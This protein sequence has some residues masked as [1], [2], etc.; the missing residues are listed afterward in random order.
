VVAGN[1]EE[2]LADQG[3]DVEQLELDDDT[4]LRVYEISKDNKRYY[5]HFLSTAQGTVYL[6]KPEQLS[7]EEVEK[8]VG[9]TSLNPVRRFGI[10]IGKYLQG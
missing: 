10:A 8:V 7:R 4:G 2:K 1:L 5:L 3:Y 6:I 9:Q